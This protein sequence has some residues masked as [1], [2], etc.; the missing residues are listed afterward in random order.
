MK[1]PV[2]CL[3]ES[4][5]PI[6]VDDEGFPWTFENNRIKVQGDY[7]KDGG[8]PCSTIGEAVA[9]LTEHGYITPKTAK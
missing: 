9:I 4:G 5:T 3:V 8:W 7:T 6:I 2:R 1:T